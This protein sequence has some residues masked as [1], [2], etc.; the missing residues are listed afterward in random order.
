[1]LG[2]NRRYFWSWWAL[3]LLILK[4]SRGN[5]AYLD[6][7]ETGSVFLQL[8][9]QIDQVEVLAGVVI[10]MVSSGPGACG[11]GLSRFS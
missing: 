1:M 11:V 3:V 8:Q 6:D 7:C 5:R 4:P 9:D 10:P 2:S